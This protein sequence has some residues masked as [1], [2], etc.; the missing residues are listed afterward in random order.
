MEMSW[1]APL[2]LAALVAGADSSVTV[3]WWRPL[4]AGA[5]L[6]GGHQEAAGRGAW[7]SREQE[8]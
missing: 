5:A 8:L 7:C 1:L 2:W 4:E 6:E 3:Q